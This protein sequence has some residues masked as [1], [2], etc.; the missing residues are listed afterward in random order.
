MAKK[1]FA[2]G[3]DGFITPM[4]KYFARE[5]VLPTFQRMLDKG[6]VNQTLPSF[7]VWTPTNWATLSTG[8]HTGTHSVSRWHVQLPSGTRVD[9]F[10]GRA[11]NAERI[12]NALERHGLKGVAV[13]YPAAHPSGVQTGFVVDGFGH[14]G[15]ACTDY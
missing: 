3:M 12:W 1:I 4:M 2:Y 5:G 13:H 9:S 8:A 6:T 7:P 14:P 11:N 10:D 15:H